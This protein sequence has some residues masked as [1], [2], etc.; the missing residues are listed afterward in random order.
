MAIGQTVLEKG[1]YNPSTFVASHESNNNIPR[2]TITS[3]ST[4]PGSSGCP[5]HRSRYRPAAR[6]ITRLRRGGGIRSSQFF[7][8]KVPFKAMNGGEAPH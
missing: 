6:H 3:D 2:L 1:N 4:A 5:V 8:L 7:L